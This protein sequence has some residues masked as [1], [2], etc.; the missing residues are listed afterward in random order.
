MFKGKSIDKNIVK[1]QFLLFS[2]IAIFA[3]SIIFQDASAS[4]LSASMKNPPQATADILTLN[5]TSGT[6]LWWVD[7][8]G[9]MFVATNADFHGSTVVYDSSGIVIRNPASTF[10]YTITGGAI[11]ANRTLNIPIITG[12]D[13]ISTL[14]LAQTNTAA[15]TFSGG[16]TMSS[17]DITLASNKVKTTTYNFGESS[18]LA[19]NV[20]IQPTSGNTRGIFAVAPSG[21][22]VAADWWL[23][24]TSDVTTNYELFHVSTDKFSTGEFDI[25]TEKGGAGTVRPINVYVDT[26]KEQSYDVAHTITTYVPLTLG[27]TVTWDTNGNTGATTVTSL[28][29]SPCH[30]TNVQ[31]IPTKLANGT[32]EYLIACH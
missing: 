1:K 7:S 27:G 6:H 26:T 18:A 24:R 4:V 13:T 25:I 20:L 32:T 21:S 10:G 9:K 22:S 5:N 12:T 31:Y 19:N 8:T 29:S 14:G 30:A 11:A 3:I 16:I 28:P 2:M 15:K 23:F 17:S